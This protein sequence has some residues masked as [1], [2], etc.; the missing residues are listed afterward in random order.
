MDSHL[1]YLTF[2]CVVTDE[3]GDST[4]ISTWMKDLLESHPYDESASDFHLPIAIRQLRA[5]ADGVWQDARF[6]S[7]LYH[8]AG[9]VV[10]AEAR[11]LAYLDEK[12]DIGKLLICMK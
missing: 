1:N 2:V 3:A 9:E 12:K 4:R 6:G 8:W 10:D 7:G 11:M 5:H